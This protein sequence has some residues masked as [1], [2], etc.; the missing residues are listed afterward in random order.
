MKNLLLIFLI[1]ISFISIN[2]QTN[3]FAPVGAKWWYSTQD[4]FP[5]EYPLTIDVYSD[6]LIE[7]KIC[8]ILAFSPNPNNVNKD[9]NI[10]LYQEDAIIYQY[11]INEAKFFKLYDFSLE[12]GQGYWCNVLDFDET[13]DSLFIE[14]EA[15]ET[16][17]IN[18][19]FLKKQIIN[20][21][22]HYD[23]FGDNIETI[24]NTQMIIPTHGLLESVQGPLR[25]YE[26]IDFG[27]YS[28]GETISCDEILLGIM[29]T[30]DLNF[31]MY[32]N[33]ASNELLI[34]FLSKSAISSYDMSIFDLTG[35]LLIENALNPDITNT[36]NIKNLPSGLLLIKIEED[37]TMV[38]FQKFI[39]D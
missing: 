20:Y 10:Y 19:H 39:K 25:C 30:E 33:P 31:E 16:I 17:E 3:I 35:K 11:F 36:I 4:F 21:D 18:G 37:G 13:L 14:I 8:S 12:A 38:K 2:A 5:A 27:L 32:P 28:T 9:R 34:E 7:G 26:D 23:W 24:G 1:S 29:E 6:T 22:G 15:V